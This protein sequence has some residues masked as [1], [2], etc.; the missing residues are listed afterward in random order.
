MPF[1]RGAP[2]SI[3]AIRQDALMIPVRFQPISEEQVT[4]GQLMATATGRQS[5]TSGRTSMRRR[6]E[7]WSAAMDL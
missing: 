2:R 7:E 6:L 5:V 3:P 1:G 4:I